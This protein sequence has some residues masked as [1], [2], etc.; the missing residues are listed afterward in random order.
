MNILLV[1][2]HSF[3]ATPQFKGVSHI[4]HKTLLCAIHRFDDPRGLAVTFDQLLTVLN[5]VT[6]QQAPEGGGRHRKVPGI[7][8][9]RS[10]DPTDSNLVQRLQW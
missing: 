6:K 7:R 9:F 4:S 3:S 2:A 1:A 10:R 5:V 8:V